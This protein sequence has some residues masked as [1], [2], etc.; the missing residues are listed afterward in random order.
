MFRFLPQFTSNSNNSRNS[1]NAKV[2]SPWSQ[3]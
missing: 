3:F 1:S 2:K